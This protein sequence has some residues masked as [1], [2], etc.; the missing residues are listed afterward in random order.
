M[1]RILKFVWLTGILRSKDSRCNKHNNTGLYVKVRN[2]TTS[3][4]LGNRCS[5]YLHYTISGKDVEKVLNFILHGL[6]CRARTCQA[7][8]TFAMATLRSVPIT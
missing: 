8:L 4:R 5:S 1:L 6:P 7:G 2:D 3:N